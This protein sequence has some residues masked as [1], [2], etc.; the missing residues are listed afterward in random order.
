MN[1]IKPA[2]L[3]VRGENTTSCW[4]IYN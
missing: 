4:K 2:K 3:R 1:G